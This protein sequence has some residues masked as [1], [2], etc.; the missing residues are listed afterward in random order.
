ML[1]NN[2][3]FSV[4]DSHRPEKQASPHKLTQGGSWE[5]LRFSTSLLCSIHGL[6][7]SWVKGRKNTGAWVTFS[8][9]FW[10]LCVNPSLLPNTN[11]DNTNKWAPDACLFNG[12]INELRNLSCCFASVM[13]HLEYL[14]PLLIPRYGVD[15]SDTQMQQ[16][17]YSLITWKIL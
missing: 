3:V 4:K 5:E 14:N 2:S 9:L 10:M 13:L 12:Y 15:R 6:C 16:V 17:S 1:D 11:Y 7:H 8:T